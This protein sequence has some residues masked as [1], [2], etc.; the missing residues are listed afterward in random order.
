M[1]QV[2]FLLR[3]SENARDEGNVI[4]RRHHDE[5]E[6]HAKTLSDLYQMIELARQNVYNELVRFGVANEVKS[7]VPQQERVR[8]IAGGNAARAGV[9]SGK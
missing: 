8:A 6:A 4:A 9:E 3:L 5:R 1:N 2:E 7:Q